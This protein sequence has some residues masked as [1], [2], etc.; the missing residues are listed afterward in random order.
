M[1][2]KIS[3]STRNI[4]DTVW[5]RI[6]PFHEMILSRSAVISYSGGKDSSLLLH[7]Y[8]WLWVEKKIPVPCIYHL[9]HSIRFNLEQEKKILDYTE[10]TFPFPNLF[11][12]KI[13]P[14]YLES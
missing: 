9:D 5:K 6:I 1:R 4:F 8:F 10:S 12:K 3:E 14:P 13:F 11:K 7:F 2:D